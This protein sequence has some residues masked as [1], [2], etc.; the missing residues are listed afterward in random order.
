[1]HSKNGYM[2]SKLSIG[3]AQFGL[4]Y[5]ISNSRGIVRI[6]EI[7]QILATAKTYGIGMLDTAQA[8]G[9]SEEQIGLANSDNF[10][11]VTKIKP[12]IKSYEVNQF[13][14]ESLSK[15]KKDN[16]YGVLFHNFDDYIKNPDSFE[17][18][19]NLK[20][21]GIVEKIG[22]SI[23][24]T[25]ELEELFLRKLNFDIIQ[26]PFNIFDQRFQPYF[27]ELKKR[28]IE[29]HVRSVFLQGLVYLDPDKLSSH[30]SKF[31]PFFK[32]FRD[33][34][35]EKELTVEEVCLKFILAHSEIDHIILGLTNNNELKK[36]IKA[37]SSTTV[38]Q[39]EVFESFRQYEIN[40][41]EII[42]P[43]NWK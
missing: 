20:N 7:N 36:N 42:L 25:E 19:Q 39:I 3:T 1:M 5:G 37:V 11:I 22:F 12:G 17:E 27:G 43:Y 33:K 18:I 31:I 32:D 28:G 14:K 30:F 8:Y 26:I 24:L 15:L 41:E 13:V 9:K 38:S 10:K 34:T 6:K 4:D 16:L 40:D 35:I 29:I 2:I 23:Y 21:T